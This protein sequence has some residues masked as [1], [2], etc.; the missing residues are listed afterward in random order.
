MYIYIGCCSYSSSSRQHLTKTVFVHNDYC[1]V[2]N[3]VEKYECEENELLFSKF[4]KVFKNGYFSKAVY[5]ENFYEY[6]EDPSKYDLKIK[7]KNIVVHCSSYREA[8][9]LLDWTI[10]EEIDSCKD[11]YEQLTNLNKLEYKLN[12]CISVYYGIINQ[13]ED[14]EKEGFE[15]WT[16]EQAIIN[17]I[18]NNKK[19]IKFVN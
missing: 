16:Y 9:S 15:I 14:F 17:I 19:K 2:R 12:S 5:Y 10:T 8:K 3:R 6:K 18:D 13:K 11:I 1:L 4:I 7:N